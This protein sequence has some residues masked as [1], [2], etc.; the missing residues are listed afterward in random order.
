M[1]S[2]F[3]S[4]HRKKIAL[5]LLLVMYSEF[6]LSG[7]AAVLQVDSYRPAVEEK[8]PVWQ[9]YSD[10]VYHNAQVVADS[11][12]EYEPQAALIDDGSGPTQPEMQSFQSVGTSNM[13]DLFSGDFS[14][15]IPLMD[16][17]GY[18]VNISYRSGIGMEQEASWV[19][20]GWN[21]N[22]GTIT[23]NMRG[24]PDEF[25]GKQDTITKTVSI[26]D[27]KTIG[28]TGGADFELT[29]LPIMHLGG[30]LGVF[31]NTYKGWGME[32]G[33]NASINAGNSA[34]GPFSGGL[35]LTNNSQE[36]F[37]VTPSFTAKLSRADGEY[38]NTGSLSMGLPY[39]SRS[40]LKGLSLSAGISQQPKDNAN[41]YSASSGLGSMISFAT[42]SYT[43][44]MS[45]PMTS[46]QY[47]FTAKIG[48]A[49]T[50]AHPSFFIS[51][52][53]SNQKIDEDDKR[54]T[55]PAFGYLNYQQAAG[56]P[57]VLLDFNREKD[58]P[59]REKPAVPNIAVPSYTYDIFSIT[60][61]GTGGMFR[62]Y[63]GDI[64]YVHD[65]ALTSKDGS[66]R[67]SVDFGTGFLVHAGADLNVNRAYTQTGPWLTQNAMRK[68]VA[69]KPSQGL[70]EGAYFKNPAE[71]TVGA[72]A[73]YE[74]I[75]GEDVVAVDLSQNGSGD[76]SIIATSY[77]NRYRSGALVQK[78]LLTPQKAVKQT[79]DK[80]AQVISYLTAE[81]ASAAGGSHYIENYAINTFSFNPCD[82]GIK[83]M[84]YTEGVGLQGAY[85][86]GR[87]F[88]SLLFI[89]NDTAVAFSNY[90]NG[91]GMG[92]LD[93]MPRGQGRKE[94]FTVRWMGRIKAPET[95]TYTFRSINDDG[96]RLYINDSLLIND[97]NDHAEKEN[98]SVPVNLVAGQMYNKIGRAHV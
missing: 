37:S 97:W 87:K 53:V 50:V 40:G 20:L 36:G 11:T 98:T 77:L 88:D 75:G 26:K 12:E 58:I 17:G 56:N 41:Q 85:Y 13:V 94:N 46:S 2:V 66:G 73:F 1:I 48:G 86:Y 63:R 82:Y 30:S 68:T 7:Y 92:R 44:T 59:Y 67:F 49:A 38:V 6:V 24:L 65:N 33:L 47:T 21:V 14:Y 32:T 28:V 34:K 64:G 57:A 18:P 19:G 51:G 29:G 83:D 9:T 81:E 25:T 71:K 61:E 69:F 78:L 22:P 15:N 96:I 16:V 60:G 35:S 39:N 23:R 72:K 10:A 90:K 84:D 89:S 54:S 95:G 70:Y 52:Y 3:T 91:I 74:G 55:V 93:T 62:A 45:Y 8:Q 79:R 27:N 42:P 31:Y 4:R 43:P 5:L 80:R 76:P